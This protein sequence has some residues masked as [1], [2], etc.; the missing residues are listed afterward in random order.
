LEATGADVSKLKERHDAARNLITLET[1]ARQALTADEIRDETA[2][3]K[4]LGD[5]IDKRMTE[6]YKGA[7][8]VTKELSELYTKTEKT[9]APRKKAKGKGVD[10]AFFKKLEEDHK[11]L[12]PLIENTVNNTAQDYV[13]KELARIAAAAES[14]T[15]KNPGSVAK[16]AE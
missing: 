4:A 10:D 12:K 9:N 2:K 5:D 13:R 11:A 14:M 3:L 8:G 15:Q 1:K 6:A 16:Y 7:G